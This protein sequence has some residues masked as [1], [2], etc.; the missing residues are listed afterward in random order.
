MKKQTV[1][2]MSFFVSPSAALSW[3]CR[4]V[5]PHYVWGEDEGHGWGLPGGEGVRELPQ[6]DVTLQRRLVSSQV[7]S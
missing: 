3:G 1:A 4:F 6:A 2:A 5:G 7:T